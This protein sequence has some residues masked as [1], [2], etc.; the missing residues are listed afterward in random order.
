MPNIWDYDPNFTGITPTYPMSPTFPPNQ[1]APSQ[2]GSMFYQPG[3]YGA[4]QDWFN[5]PISQQ[6]R[7]E[8]QNLAYGYY[9]NQQGIANND[10]AFNQWF[11]KQ[12]PKFQ[13]SYGMAS[14]ENPLL[15]VDE[16]LK[17]LPSYAQLQGQYQMQSPTARGEQF[18][19]Y[20]PTVRWMNR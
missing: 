4:T 1:P 5:T 14:M 2:A 11:Y 19:N 15:T 13:Q 18:N 20:S 6:M 9:G 8:N 12:F 10:S 16:F 7:E 17:T 3:Q